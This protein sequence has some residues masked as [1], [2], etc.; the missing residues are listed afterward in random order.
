[1]SSAANYGH[2]LNTH[3]KRHI[4]RIG[5]SESAMSQFLF[6]MQWRDVVFQFDDFIVVPTHT[7][8]SGSCCCTF[9]DTLVG[10]TTAADSG[11]TAFL[12]AAGINGVLSGA[13]G[14]SA[15]D[16]T[17]ILTLA[18][19]QGDNNAGQEMRW[20][21]S[22]FEGSEWFQ[23]FTDPLSDNTLSPLN[24]IDT[25]SITNGAADVAGFGM[26]TAQTL[27]TAAFITDGVTACMNTTATEVS[28]CYT[29][30]N[31][32][33]LESRIQLATNAAMGAIFENGALKADV[34]NHGALTACQ[35]E[36]ATDL[37]A[38][39]VYG[40]LACA[41]VTALIDYWAMWQ[42]RY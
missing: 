25:P 27:A 7:V 4:D 32:T 30:T 40:T 17:A 24:D 21:T 34:I 3:T 19:F 10:Y 5:P 14:C 15:A 11:A 39:L 37:T 16:Y 13:T 18:D 33:Y 1:M 9:T 28:G 20:Q 23:G 12:P 36:G 42:D 41:C 6:P 2:T 29:P 35:I 31:S 8:V 22:N 38:R 26:D